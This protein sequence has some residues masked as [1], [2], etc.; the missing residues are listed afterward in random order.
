PVSG[1]RYMRY[2]GNTACVSISSDT[3]HL[4]ILDAGSGI[5]EL[6]L[7]LSNAGGRGAG[8]PSGYLL[9]SHTHWDHIQ[10]F[11]FFG[12]ACARQARFSI[13][14]GC[15]ESGGLKALLAGQ[16]D[17]GYFPVPFAALPAHLSFH[18]LCEGEH[19][20]D[21]VQLALQEQRHTQPSTAF[22]L[23]FGARA[24][25][26]ASD[27]EPMNPPTPGNQLMGFD[28]VDE[29]LVA[30]ARGADML[31]HDAQYTLDEYQS[32]VGW[33]HNVPEVAVDTAIL[34]GVRRLVLFHHD[35][36]RTDDQIDTML[37]RARE[38]AGQM[39]A[40]DL[41]VLAAHDGLNLVL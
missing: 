18:A 2:G 9:L 39:G 13:I 30:F 6:G 12:P 20:L 11:P 4:F 37:Y 24:V 23:R 40:T 14:G 15:G 34:A 25:V 32:H 17:E 7:D 29:R 10:G 3:G 27:N 36:V 28:V 19:D 38:R 16:M 22:R 8:P 33:G 41:E 5:R 1:A 26:Y 35:P 21:C 31:I